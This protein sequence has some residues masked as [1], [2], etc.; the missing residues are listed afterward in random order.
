MEITLN[1]GIDL[2]TGKKLGIETGEITKF[3]TYN[4]LFEAY[5]NS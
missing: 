4:E 1:N 3:E 5:K 2:M